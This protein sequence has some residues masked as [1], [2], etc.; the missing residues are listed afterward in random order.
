MTLDNLAKIG[1]LK[2]H[3]ASKEE[4]EAER[5]LHEATNWLEVNHREL[6]P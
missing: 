1:R 3:V 6:A 2:V 5:L 4:Q